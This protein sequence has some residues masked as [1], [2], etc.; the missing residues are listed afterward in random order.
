M[1]GILRDW[2]AQVVEDELA[3]AVRSF[4]EGYTPGKH[5]QKGHLACSPDALTIH[6]KKGKYIQ[7]VDV[8]SSSPL[9]I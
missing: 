1:P 3:A 5:M 9:K 8:L 6:L 2:I 4:R 7:I